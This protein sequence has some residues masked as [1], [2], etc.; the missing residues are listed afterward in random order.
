MRNRFYIWTL[1]APAAREF[2]PHENHSELRYFY[3]LAREIDKAVGDHG[4]TF[5]LTWHLDAFEERFRD[6]VVI[7][8]GDERHQLPSYAG[9][10]RAIF[11]TGGTKRNPLRSTVSLP[12]AVA[13]RVALRELRDG[14]IRRRRARGVSA[15]PPVFELPMG[16]FGLTEVPYLPF[17]ERQVD[18]FFAGSI[19]S[20]RGFTLRPRLVARRQMAAALETARDRLP[21]LSVDYT[22]AGPFANPDEMLDAETYSARLMRARIVLCPRGNF[23]ETFRLC[24]AAKFGCVAVAERL[25]ERWYHHGTPAIQIDSWGELPGT[26]ATLTADASALAERAAQM[27]EWWTECLSEAAAAQHLAKNL[28][29]LA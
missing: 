7:L 17:A 2:E 25:P 9:A 6:A 28:P 14:A 8:I 15:P 29:P 22:N 1:D 5:L 13:W 27:R 18:V 20:E 24:E 21:G 11:K 3:G 19:E 12:P 4:I 26:L 23:D 10:V 16:Y